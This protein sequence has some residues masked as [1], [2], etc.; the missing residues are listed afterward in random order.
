VRR[1]GSPSRFAETRGTKNRDITG[2]Y[3]TTRVLSAFKG[4]P[5]FYTL[6]VKEPEELWKDNADDVAAIRASGARLRTNKL[7]NI[8]E[9]DAT[10]V[11][12]DWWNREHRVEKLHELS[13][14]RLPRRTFYL[15]P[16]L[17]PRSM[18][19]LRKFEISGAAIGDSDLYAIENLVEL[20]ELSLRNCWGV[21]DVTAGRLTALTKLESLNLAKTPITDAGVA[22]LAVLD[23]L[24]ALDLS[25]TKV[26]D[27]GAAALKALAHLESLDIDSI[28]VTDAGLQQLGGLDR[29]RSFWIVNAKV[30]RDGVE[31]LRKKSPKLSITSNFP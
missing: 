7:G 16:D 26:A 22:K 9:I 11:K 6:G 28:S 17:R 21:T 14:L 30:T 31:R 29:L 1:W 23:K 10:D 19:T 24:T 20:R 27:K 4:V 2:A 8:T 5:G 3:V 25:D 15:F 13:V 12:E 18:R